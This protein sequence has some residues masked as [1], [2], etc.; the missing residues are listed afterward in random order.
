MCLQKNL[1]R[2]LH[3]GLYVCL[4]KDQRVCLYVRIHEFKN[5]LLDSAST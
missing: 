4:H 1:Q 5:R 3:E 2:D